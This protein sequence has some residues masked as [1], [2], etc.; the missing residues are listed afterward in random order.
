LL[1]LL[2][3]SGLER[4]DPLV[5]TVL[6]TTFS[7]LQASWTDTVTRTRNKII[8]LVAGSLTVAVILLVVP[9]RFLTL[10]SAVAL[11][12]G[13]WYIATRPALGNAFM[14]IV[15]VGFNSVTRD[16]DAVN[17]LVQY[18]GLTLCAVLV[19]VVLG[20]SVIPGFRPAPLRRR[21]RIATEATAAALRA[22][23]NRTNP[24]RPE[25]I[26]LFRDAARMQAELVP[27]H[28]QL[29]DAQL[30]EL[31][32]LRTGLRDLTVLAEATELTRG[33]LDQ[34]LQ[35]LSPDDRTAR[36]AQEHTAEGAPGEASSTLWDLAQQA[37]SAERNLLRTLPAG[38]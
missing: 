33:E 14:V 36:N 32:V 22:S 26:A 15:S 13:L 24:Q 29:D 3:T 20:Y 34:A 10:V 6:L 19:G 11:C 16:L 9:S 2:I 31:D 18:V 38:T 5:S 12:L 17:L 4:G 1:M 23:S 35:V 21:I 27:D 37:G 7:I 25:E 8:G 30:A 28:D